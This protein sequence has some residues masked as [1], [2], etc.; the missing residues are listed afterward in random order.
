[1]SFS[2]RRSVFL[3]A[4][5]FLIPS[6][7][8][9]QQAP[10]G[11]EI[12]ERVV[13]VVGDSMISMT[14]LEEGL[15]QM[16]GRG[17]ARP[18]GAAE[19]LEARLGLLEQMINQHLIIQEAVKDTLLRIS[20]EELEDRVQQQIDAQVIQFGTLRRLQE[21]LAEENRTMAVYRE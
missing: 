20:D 21:A 7:A 13:A 10:Q 19:L 8:E 6:A 11:I 15:L 12:V 1:M 3:A 9:G 14:E 2:S 17:W 4:A 5:F 16:E 18:T